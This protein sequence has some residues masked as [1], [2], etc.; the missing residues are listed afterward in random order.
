MLDRYIKV[1]KC[2]VKTLRDLSKTTSVSDEECVMCARLCNVL[3]SVKLASDVLCR[4]YANLITADAAI[5]F[6]IDTLTKESNKN[7][8]HA[9]VTREAVIKSI[10]ER[11]N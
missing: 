3:K 5:T 7:N 8:T 10:N 1:R 6:L 4:N 9:K 2:V 11:R